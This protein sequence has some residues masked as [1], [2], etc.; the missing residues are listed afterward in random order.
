MS[1]DLCDWMH[2]EDNACRCQQMIFHDQGPHIEDISRPRHSCRLPQIKVNI[3][4]HQKRHCPFEGLFLV[5]TIYNLADSP[6][7]DTCP[8]L[9]MICV[10]KTS[11][12]GLLNECVTNSQTNDMGQDWT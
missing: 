11:E 6:Q 3:K 1:K 12:S 9:S 7:F 2:G 10:S 8:R 4:I 5:L